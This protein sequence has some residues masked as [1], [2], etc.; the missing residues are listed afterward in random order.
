MS[1]FDFHWMQLL[2]TIYCCSGVCCNVAAVSVVIV[3]A[4][5]AVISIVESEAATN[6]DCCVVGVVEDNGDFSEL[7]LWLDKLSPQCCC[8][9]WSLETLILLLSVG[10]RSSARE[11]VEATLTVAVVLEC[12]VITVLAI[13]AMLLSS[14]SEQ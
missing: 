13:G 12:G 1:V 9:L 14:P 8:S 10:F 2:T 5:A 3:V 6:A 7:S 4:A 11:D